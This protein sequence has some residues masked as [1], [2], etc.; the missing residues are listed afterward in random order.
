MKL[1]IDLFKIVRVPLIFLEAAVFLLT[2]YQVTATSGLIFGVPFAFATAGVCAYVYK[3]LMYPYGSLR[4]VFVFSPDKL[5]QSEKG[6]TVKEISLDSGLNVY[7]SL[8]ITRTYLV[9]SRVEIPQAEPLVKW[10]KNPEVVI[11]PYFP[12]KMPKLKRYYEKA[13]AI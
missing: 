3:K 7:R 4:T 10:K 1:T 6:K 9:F 5:T 2:L 13:K 8:S 12:A 11:L